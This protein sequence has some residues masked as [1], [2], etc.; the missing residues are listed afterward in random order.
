MQKI[1][2][3]GISLGER[4]DEEPNKSNRIRLMDLRFD[5]S[6]ELDLIAD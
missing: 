4:G 2:E 5:D 1:E 6:R 3:P